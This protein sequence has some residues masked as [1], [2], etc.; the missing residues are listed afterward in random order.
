MNEQKHT[1]TYDEMEQARGDF[2]EPDVYAPEHDP[3]VWDEIMNLFVEPLRQGVRSLDLGQHM[4]E[5]YASEQ[6]KTYKWL[7]ENVDDLR[8]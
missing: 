3:N 2:V 5:E 7:L 1:L 4:S 8:K 6:Y